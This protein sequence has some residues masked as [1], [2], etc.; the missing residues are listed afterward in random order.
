MISISQS[1]YINNLLTKVNITSCDVT[2]FLLSERKKFNPQTGTTN[3][4][5][6]HFSQSIK[7]DMCLKENKLLRT[8][9]H[10]TVIKMNKN[11][12]PYEFGGSSD[13]ILK[14]SSIRSSCA[15]AMCDTMFAVFW[16]AFSEPSGDASLSWSPSISL[17]YQ[18]PARSPEVSNKNLCFSENSVNFDKG[19]QNNQ[20]R[21]SACA[22]L[23]SF[24]FSWSQAQ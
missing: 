22:L 15:R 2:Q 7:Q 1:R 21:L 3:S 12:G 23:S 5:S 10:S 20:Q 19:S 24:L 17:K 6:S 16:C 9:L 11:K 18:D 4:W 14:E 13:W 8:N